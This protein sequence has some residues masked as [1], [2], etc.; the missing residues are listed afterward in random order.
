MRPIWIAALALLVGACSAPIN[1]VAIH[2]IAADPNPARLAPGCSVHLASV[3]DARPR[4]DGSGQ[5]GRHVLNI[6]DATGLLRDALDRAGIAPATPAAAPALHLRLLRFYV[7]QQ[8]VTNTPVLVLEARVDD[9]RPF[10]VRPL[11]TSINWAAS[12]N[13]A[14]AEIA[15]VFNAGIR[16]LVGRLNANCGARPA[17]H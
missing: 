1:R 17:S 6:P 14:Q 9:G 13:E 2:R 16:D 5:V 11:A 8:Y 15:V 4:E 12:E 7:T 3:G 10:I